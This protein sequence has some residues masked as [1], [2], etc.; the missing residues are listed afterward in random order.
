M[1][2]LSCDHMEIGVDC[3][4]IKRFVQFENNELVLAKI[5][6]DNEVEY[7]K[8]K[9]RTSQHLAVRFAG[10]EAVIKAISQ[11]G[12]Q[13][14]LKQIEILNDASGIPRV[15]LPEEYHNTYKVKISLSHSDELA[16]AFVII[17]R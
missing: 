16:I 12:I 13:L 7:C 2:D 14:S 9:K 11:Y 8:K 17:D 10:K 4:E 15:I 6:T 3:I 5:F 1:A